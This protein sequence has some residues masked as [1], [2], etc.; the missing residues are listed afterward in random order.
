MGIQSV[1]YTLPGVLAFLE[2]YHSVQ[3]LKKKLGL[4]EG[5][6]AKLS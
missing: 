2:Y 4:I 3:T 6:Q 5:L 1:L